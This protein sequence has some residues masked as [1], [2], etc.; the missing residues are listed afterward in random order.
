M[1]AHV[2][3]LKAVNLG[4]KT[5][6]SMAALR[7][8]AQELGWEQ[9]RT[10]LQ[11]GNLVFLVTHGGQAALETA[12]EAAV[13]RRFDRRTAVFVRDAAAWTA[14]IAANPFKGAAT[15]D[16]GHMLLMAL[17]A[18]PPAGA[19]EA[20]RAAIKGR[21]SVE[22]RGRDAYLIYPDG[23]GASKLTT[24]II[25]KHLGGPGTARNWNTVLKI[26]EAM[27]ALG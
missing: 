24:A 25:E 4:G 16:P 19:V 3:L 21:E 6:V 7:D 1:A 10:L 18:P 9:P 23:I 17:K 22:V 8:L 2:A 26:D 5:M 14:A 20:L 27:R 11:S 13:A 15:S 12:L